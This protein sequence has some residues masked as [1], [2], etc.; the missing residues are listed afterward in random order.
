MRDRS[1]EGSSTS[2]ADTY[3]QPPYQ[4]VVHTDRKRVGVHDGDALQDLW[5]IFLRRHR[6]SEAETQGSQIGRVRQVKPG[7]IKYSN[8]ATMGVG[9]GVDNAGEVG[10]QE[11]S[12]PYDVVISDAMPPERLERLVEGAHV[13]DEDARA[14]VL[15]MTGADKLVAIELLDET[16]LVERQRVHW[17]GLEKDPKWRLTGERGRAV[18][19]MGRVGHTEVWFAAAKGHARPSVGV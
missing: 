19:V 18:R 4:T 2:G 9:P 7:E 10:N 11:H 5:K 16:E 1:S 17:G 13:V 8:D 14:H 12:M 6:E 3:Q 15:W